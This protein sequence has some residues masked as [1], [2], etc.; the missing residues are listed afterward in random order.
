MSFSTKRK[1]PSGTESNKKAKTNGNIMSFFGGPKAATTTTTTTTTNGSST[2]ATAAPAIRFD[3]EKWV[4][5]LK[6]E[7]KELLQLEIDT[8]DESW[9]AQLKDEL[10]TK[11]F[12]ELKRFLNREWSGPKKIFPPK[13]DIYSWHVYLPSIARPCLS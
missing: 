6:P 2:P 3:K 13:E 8:M 10:V 7:Q 12:L 5:T 1:A 9:L 4:A 11:E